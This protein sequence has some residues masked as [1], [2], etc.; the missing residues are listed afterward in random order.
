MD[1]P[2]PKRKTLLVVDDNALCLEGLA[3]LLSAAG[4]DVL[5]AVDGMEALAVLREQQR[6]DVVLLDMMLPVLDGWAFLKEQQ[7]D[8]ELASIPVI[9]VSAISIGSAEW[10]RSLGAAGF[11]RK[12]TEVA[13]IVKVIEGGLPER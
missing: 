6:A 2:E 7:R 13:P 9:I 3:T 10:A 5:T 4:Y 12:P 11:V 8:P 1:K